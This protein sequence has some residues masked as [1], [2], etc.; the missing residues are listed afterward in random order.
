MA[1]I[2]VIGAGKCNEEIYDIAYHVGK[3]IAESKNILI[4]GGLFGVMEA[5]CK[6]A[7]EHGGIT[8]GIL[9]GDD[10]NTANK[11]VSIPIATNM[12]HAR[13][14]II[15]TTSSFLIAVGGGYG[16]LSEIS[17]GLKNNKKVYS[18]HSWDIPGVIK[19]RSV[20]DLQ[21]TV[22]VLNL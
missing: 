10:I 21:K 9:P 14:I 12:G 20:K 4:C 22:K 5:S 6:G 18:L 1:I 11:F 16:T 19:I 7:V 2:G 17:I 13:N 8:I 15:S 3:L